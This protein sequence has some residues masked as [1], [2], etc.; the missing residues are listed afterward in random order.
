MNRK[1]SSQALQPDGTTTTTTDLYY[2]A[3]CATLEEEEIVNLDT[4]SSAGTSR[5]GQHHDVR[6][7][8]ER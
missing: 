6:S 3:L 2:D 7:D 8:R 4:S 1:K 5:P